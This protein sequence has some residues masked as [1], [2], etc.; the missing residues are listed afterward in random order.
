[1]SGNPPSRAGFHYALII[2]EINARAA[3]RLGADLL[4]LEDDVT[5]RED[6]DH[7][8]D[9][10]G[11]LRP[12]QDETLGRWQRRA[13]QCA[14]ELADEHRTKR[15]RCRLQEGQRDLGVKSVWRDSIKHLRG[16]NIS[17]VGAED[18]LRRPSDQGRREWF[19]DQ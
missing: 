10:P 2:L 18:I 8:G 6:Q 15:T 3:P 1:M 7:C 5:G 13:E 19:D 16:L 12:D 17:E 11:Y 14:A 9:Q 4:A